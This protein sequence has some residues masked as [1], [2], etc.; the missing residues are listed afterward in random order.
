[1]KLKGSL[2][3]VA[4]IASGTVASQ[5]IIVLMAPVV[6]RLYSTGEFGRYSA[7]IAATA[8]IIPAAAFRFEFSVVLPEDLDQARRLVRIALGAVVLSSVLSAIAVGVVWVAWPGTPWAAVPLAPLWAGLLVFLGGTFTVLTQAALRFRAY[9][10]VAKRAPIQS[11]ATAI[12]QVGFA[13]L[14]RSSVSLV[15]AQVVGRAFGLTAL[16]KTIRPLL[17]RPRGGSYAATVRQYWRFPVILAPSALLNSLGI[18]LP[19]LL[20]AAWFGAT[21]AG[22]LGMAQRL[23]ILPGSVIGGAI[24]QVFGAETARRLRER[25]GGCRRYYLRTSLA[26]GGLALV[27]L[28]AFVLLS[29]WAFPFFLGS[30]WQNSGTLA[31][32]LALSAA[33]ALVVA[34]VSTVYLLFQSAATL[35]MDLSRVALI[36]AVAVFIQLNS[37]G[38]LEACWF[39]VAAQVIYYVALWSYGLRIVTREERAR[40]NAPDPDP[41]H[42]ANG[43]PTE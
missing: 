5:A 19:L 22:E 10:V 11:A 27:V 17:V 25:S 38:P 39:L 20:M 31:Q 6:S 24:A 14:S 32:A 8:V 9:K 36:C 33:C 21:T 7:L 35:V 4:T 34:P 30:Q 1:M 42:G 13:A 2:G 40:A 28:V 12:T 41:S 3:G 26:T 16:L 43:H 23:V 37:Y 29:P 15:A 18:Q